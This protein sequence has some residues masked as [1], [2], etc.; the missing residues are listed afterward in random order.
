MN[1]I[2]S[3]GHRARVRALKLEIE[4]RYAERLKAAGILGCVA[5]RVQMALEFRR[6][7]AKF[8]PSRSALFLER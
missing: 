6:G 8:G 2:V 7:R 3:D 1:T 4:A 5:L